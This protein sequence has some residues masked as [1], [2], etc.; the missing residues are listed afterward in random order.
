MSD[1]LAAMDRE[2]MRALVRQVLRDVLPE[3]IKANGA[4]RAAA[5]ASSAA[6]GSPARAEAK[7]ESR[8]ERRAEPK[9][10]L[11]REAAK[12]RT[13]APP[14]SAPA[15]RRTVIE[16][17][18]LYTDQDLAK[19][20]RRLIQLLDDPADREAVR[21][22]RHLFRLKRARP[23]ATGVG[24]LGAPTNAARP[25]GTV[26][27]IAQGVVKESTVVAAA[28]AGARLVVGK[29]V[30]VTPLA[31]DKARQLGVQIERDA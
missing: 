18:A 20:V 8:P 19:F 26:E 30:V 7:P 10:D 13:E 24:G 29:G 14:R 17:V 1:R 27:R 15:D 31:R 5:G 16:E 12:P 21:A 23:A 2:A 22:G 6:A 9:P 3:A 4:L 11:R 28:K 25:V